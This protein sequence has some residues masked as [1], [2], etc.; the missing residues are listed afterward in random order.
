MRRVAHERHIARVKICLN[1]SE[2]RS[3]AGCTFT[4]ERKGFPA[5]AWNVEIFL[6]PSFP[7]SL[8]SSSLLPLP[9]SLSLSLSLFLSLSIVFISFATQLM[10]RTEIFFPSR[11][12]R[13]VVYLKRRDFIAHSRGNDTLSNNH[14]ARIPWS[15]AIKQWRF[16][17]QWNFWRIAKSPKEILVSTS[18]KFGKCYSWSPYTC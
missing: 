8:S 18:K 9:L 7:L 12:K 11:K 4:K 2:L 16:C 15:R 10:Y 17:E 5:N 14:L 6:F 13:S 3:F 1:R